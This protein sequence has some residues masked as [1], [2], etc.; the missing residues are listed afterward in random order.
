MININVLVWL[1]T[2]LIFSFGAAV[3]EQQKRPNLAY[4]S[5]IY[6]RHDVRT[7]KVG[8]LYSITM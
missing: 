8:F 6:D 3:A 4:D 7:N 5:K 1:L 2:L